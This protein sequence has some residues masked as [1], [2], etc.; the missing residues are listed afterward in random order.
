MRHMKVAVIRPAVHTIDEQFC[1]Y[2]A[3]NEFDITLI[4][5]KNSI[6]TP[7]KIYHPNFKVKLL[8]T[9]N[10][11]I[12]TDFPIT[13]GL[14]SCLKKE[15]FDIVQANEDFQFTTWVSALYCRL[16]AKRLILFE[17]KYFFPRHKL[18]YGLYQ[19]FRRLFF[20]FV[21][22]TSSTIVC[23]SKAAFSFIKEIIEPAFRN[24][25][26]I[27]TIG[28]NTSLFHPIHTKRNEKVLRIF[29]IAR[30][31]PNKDYPT[32]V[33]AIHYIK[34]HKK[35]PISLA[36]VGRGYLYNSLKQQVSDYDLQNDVKIIRQIPYNRL[37]HY[38][39]HHDI[40]VLPS[41]VEPN[42][43]VVVEAMACGLPV[44]ISNVGGMLDFVEDGRNGYIFAVGDYRDL[45]DKILKLVDKEKREKLSKESLKLVKEKF[46]WDVL[47]KKYIKVF[48][49]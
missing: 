14:Y 27:L 33:K 39:S 20:R 47:I 4:A 13:L 18:D 21:W 17:D 9:M 31:I 11:G 46:D 1:N 5:P 41:V 15:N 8:R 25:L 48:K 45:A 6:A 3:K 49:K 34:N 40:F 35:I 42:G 7:N 37:K 36:I 19:I 43:S 10:F 30:L 12:F 28:V 24:K 23:R 16:Y 38:Y 32:L 44:I 2:L 22:N 26:T 29:T